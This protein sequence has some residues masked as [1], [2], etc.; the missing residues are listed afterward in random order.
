MPKRSKDKVSATRLSRAD[1]SQAI[2]VTNRIM[3]AERR[4]FPSASDP[5]KTYTAMIMF[6]GKVMCDCRGWTMKKEGKPRRCTHTD[7][8][9]GGRRTR[10]DAEYMYLVIA[11]QDGN[12]EMVQAPKDPE[13][14]RLADLRA[15]FGGS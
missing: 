14:S 9:V 12:L 5:G 6:D 11:K 8:M 10:N 13:E 1:R 4:E 2:R 3:S 15:I 7:Q